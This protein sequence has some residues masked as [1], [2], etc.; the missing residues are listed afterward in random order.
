MAENILNTLGNKK[1][2]KLKKKK[3][4]TPKLIKYGSVREFTQLLTGHMGV[5]GGVGAATNTSVVCIAV[6][7]FIEEHRVLLGDHRLQALYKKA[8]FEVVKPGDV[9]LD[10]GTG[11]GLHAFFACQAG[12][13]RVYAI[14]S[15]GVIQ[16]AKEAAKANGFSEK[17]QF[18][19]GHSRSINLPEKV[20]V[21]ISNTGYIGLVRDIPDAKERF[22]KK[23]GTIIP[24]SL[25]NTFVPVEMDSFYKEKVES[26]SE[27]HYGFD[28]SAFK[29]FALNRPHGDLGTDE[30]FMAN[31]VDLSPLNFLEPLRLNYKWDAEYR[32]KRDGVITGLKGWYSFMLSDNV[33][34]TTKPPL[35]LSPS[36]WQQHIL[37]LKTPL[38]VKKGDILKVNFAVYLKGSVSDLIW[39]WTVTNKDSETTQTSFDAIPLSKELLAKLAH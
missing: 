37:P 9:V 24:H 5:D 28:F 34:L 1:M 32:I 14:E 11:S 21:I 3:Y 19:Y 12:A 25:I 15:Q 10:L 29:P 22:L 33:V 20:D 13:S 6:A 39:Q 4:K 30:N 35:T 26:W 38:E 18:I 16:L 27:N 17:I 31:P 2:K 7:P 36:L 8:I 23:G